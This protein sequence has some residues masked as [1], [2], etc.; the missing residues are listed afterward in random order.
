M[1]NDFNLSRKIPIFKSYE[2]EAD[3]FLKRKKYNFVPFL[4]TDLYFKR[5]KVRVI[6]VAPYFIETSLND[7]SFAK[8]N[9]DPEALE[10][11]R[12]GFEGKKMMTPD[13]AALKLVNTLCEM[14]AI[15]PGKMPRS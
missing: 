10:I 15:D 11:I 4:Q 9:S 1:L 6:A 2:A 8:W 14:R 13:E 3:R 5:H 7:D 12:K